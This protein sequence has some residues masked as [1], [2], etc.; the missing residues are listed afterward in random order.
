MTTRENMG[1]AMLALGIIIL[2][3]FVLALLFMLHWVIGCIGISIALIVIGS[4]L[5]SDDW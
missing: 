3:G 1:I 2:C 4:W 5:A